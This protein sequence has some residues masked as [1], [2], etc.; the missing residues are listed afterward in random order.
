MT[1]AAAAQHTLLGMAPPSIP[2]SHSS[3]PG[4]QW[5]P[6]A[7][8]CLFIHWGIAS[9]HGGIDL[10][11]GMMANTP[12]DQ[13]A[14]GVNKVTPEQYWQLAGRFQ[15]DAFDP[16][17]WI[18]E[19]AAAGFRY[20][21]FT[22]MHHDGYTLWP[23]RVS[24]FGVQSHLNH[25]D[26]VAPFVRACRRHGLKVGLYYSPTDWRFDRDW[27]SFNYLSHGRN[28]HSGSPHFN[29]RHET[30]P[31]PEYP[32]DHA[33][34][35][36]ALNLQRIGELLSRYDA[37]DLLWLDGGVYDNALRDQARALQ[38]H[39]VLNN[40]ACDG[41]FG[42]SECSFPTEPPDGWFETCHCWQASTILSPSGTPVDIWGYLK[43]EQYKSTDWMLIHLDA[44][45]Q[46][47]ANFLVNVGPRPDGTLPEIVY[48]RFQETRNWM[49]AHP[50]W[51]QHH[52]EA[53]V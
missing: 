53:T 29:V 2:E 13:S 1:N 8:L 50:E 47:H 21:V 35:L 6:K 4:A 22:T 12:W 10:S 46:W 23:S 5:F 40:R 34:Q 51:V 52:L 31:A 26:L 30:V 32:S 37:I 48:T 7:G 28:R 49:E 38:P 41:D 39:I 18:E 11:W 9:A 3:H 36:Q 43:E 44:L 24:D 17:R 15:P 42:H 45:R 14:E 16:D 33:R 27:M 25:R 20:A 19:A